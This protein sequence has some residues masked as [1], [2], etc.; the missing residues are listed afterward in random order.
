MQMIS[1]QIKVEPEE[2]ARAERN[3]ECHS[4]VCRFP[5]SDWGLMIG[6]ISRRAADLSV[7]HGKGQE[8][9]IRVHA[10]VG[11]DNVQGP[12]PLAGNVCDGNLPESLTNAS[13]RNCN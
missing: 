7:Y 2:L 4:I 9:L 12:H 6:R 3:V 1:G 5:G 13:H 8:S 10:P 11:V